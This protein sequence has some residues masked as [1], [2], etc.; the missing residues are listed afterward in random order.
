MAQLIE[1]IGNHLALVAAF[2]GVLVALVI[3]IYQ[4]GGAG[5]LSPQ[6]AVLLLNQQEALP[7]DL[8]PDAEYRAGHIINA[9][10]VGLQD[11]AAGGTKLEK[12][13]SRPLLLYCESGAQ[14]GGAVKSLRK[15]GYA[16][17]HHLKGGL[18]AWRGEQLPVMA[19]KKT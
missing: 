13:K 18:S 1:F 14:A 5:A 8:R 6:Q 19:G 12:Y 15:L 2:A 3:T 17:V 16:K 10:N 4:G 11:I 9:V 7:V